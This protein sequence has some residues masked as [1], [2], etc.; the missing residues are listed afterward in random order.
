[1]GYSDIPDD[2]IEMAASHISDR[3]NKN[4]SISIIGADDNPEAP[5]YFEIIPFNEIDLSEI[6]FF[7]ID[8]SY[9]SQ[10]FYNGVS[11][12]I[13]AGGYLCYRRGCQQKVNN[14]D[15]PVIKGYS[16]YPRNMLITNEGELWNIYDELISMP[17]VK[18]LIDFFNAKPEEIFP[19]SREVICRDLSSLLSFAQEIIEWSLIYRIAGLDIVKN[20]DFILK[21]GALRSLNI[22]QRYL[23]EL[24]K[25]LKNKGLIIVGITK[26]SPIKMELSYT[27]KIGRAHV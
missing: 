20:G 12:G 8:G 15:D 6:N 1:M 13:Y 24:G 16:C 17:D 9:N 14:I 18:G 2:I 22:K 3:L 11:I 10:S 21:D 19:Y 5:H 7:A 23:V 27:F 26:N 25:F 4:H